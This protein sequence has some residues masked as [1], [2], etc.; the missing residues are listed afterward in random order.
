MSAL[1][2]LPKSIRSSCNTAGSHIIEGF[3]FGADHGAARCPAF[4]GGGGVQFISYQ[5]VFGGQDGVLEFFPQRMK[6]RVLQPAFEEAELHAGAVVF[7]DFGHAME[8][9][10]AAADAA[11]APS[12]QSMDVG[13]LDGDV[14][15]L[16]RIGWIGLNILED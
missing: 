12:S 10:E 8:A 16:G 5:A 11:T 6:G 4:A 15:N 1:R 9:F 13:V 7:A 3:S 2:V 14:K